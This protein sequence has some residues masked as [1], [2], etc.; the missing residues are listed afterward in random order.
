MLLSFEFVFWRVIYF[1][2]RISNEPN[3]L[4]I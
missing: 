1:L 2:T 3:Y 4:L